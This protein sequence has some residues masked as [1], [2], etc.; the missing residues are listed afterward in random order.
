[1]V[2]LWF[3]CVN[4]KNKKYFKIFFKQNVVCFFVFEI[5]FEYIWLE[6]ILNLYFFSIFNNFNVLISKIVKSLK[7]IL[8]HF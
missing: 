2:F 6:K 4:I 3:L 1:M 8:I 5:V 7:N